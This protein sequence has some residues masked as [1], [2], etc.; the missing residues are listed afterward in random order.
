MQMRL[1]QNEASS[2]GV[3]AHE[4]GC[5]LH[6]VQEDSSKFK[7]FFCGGGQY[8]DERTAKQMKEE[9]MRRVASH[10]S[11]FFLSF[12]VFWAF[13]QH[14]GVGNFA[15]LLHSSRRPHL[16]PTSPTRRCAHAALLLVRLKRYILQFCN[17]LKGFWRLSFFGLVVFWNGEKYHLLSCINSKPNEIEWRSQN[18]SLIGKCLGLFHNWNFLKF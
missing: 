15:A 11:H 16:P 5:T 17:S 9:S 10:S 4:T 14:A 12:S 1:L 7:V 3:A 18:T 6:I 13:S 2:W 8:K